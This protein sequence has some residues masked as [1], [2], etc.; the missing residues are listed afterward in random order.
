ME[1]ITNYINGSLVPPVGEKYI[2]NYLSNDINRINIGFEYAP[3]KGFPIRAG[4][5]YVM[6]P[7]MLANS[8]DLPDLSIF[9]IGTGR[10]FGSLSIDAA[11]Q[12]HTL[13]YYDDGQFVDP[14]STNSNT[15]LDKI[16]ENNLS[17]LTTLKWSF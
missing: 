10:D 13:D 5:E 3:I 17:F 11:L 8:Y 15:M 7:I 2:D 6:R 14:N 4:F 1:K 9:T 16:I 12:Y